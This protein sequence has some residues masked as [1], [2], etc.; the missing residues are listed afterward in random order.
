MM[1]TAIDF[2]KQMTELVYINVPGPAEPVPGMTGGELLHGFLSDLKTMQDPEM[3]AWF[4]SLCL[5]WNIHY[6]EVP[7]K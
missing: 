4:E 7:A 1:G 5:K 6:R 3:N 2:K